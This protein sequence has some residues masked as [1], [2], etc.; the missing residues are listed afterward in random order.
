M[1]VFFMNSQ[2]L[3][4]PQDWVNFSTIWE[5]WIRGIQKLMK[6]GFSLKRVEHKK[7][8]KSTF[9]TKKVKRK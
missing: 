3:M 5:K 1:D 4:N 2:D 7:R 8:F 6:R 9:F